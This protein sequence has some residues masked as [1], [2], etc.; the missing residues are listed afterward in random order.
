MSKR[1]FYELFWPAWQRALTKKNIKSGW[2]KAGIN[3]F[4]PKVVL[5]Q[6]VINEPRPPSNDSTTLEISAGD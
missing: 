2:R 5:D 1:Y 4:D 6:L 3:P